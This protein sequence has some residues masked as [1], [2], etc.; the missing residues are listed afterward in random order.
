MQR[1]KKPPQGTHGPIKN[2]EKERALVEWAGDK[3]YTDIMICL[4]LE[5]ELKDPDYLALLEMKLEGRL[6]DERAAPHLT[7]MY[8]RHPR[9]VVGRAYIHLKFTSWEA[10]AASRKKQDVS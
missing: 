6:N 4:A 5:R 3:M 10:L 1:H 7:A 9:W 8:E 2:M